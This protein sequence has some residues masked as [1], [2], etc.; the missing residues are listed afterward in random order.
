MVKSHLIIVPCHSLWKID[1]GL[2]PGNYGQS[3]K[4]WFLAPFQH[5]GR[6]HLSFV[7]HSLLAINEL[8]DDTEHSLL[9]FSGSCTKKEAGTVSEAQS[10]FLHARKLLNAVS[11]GFD[12]PL[13]FTSHEDIWKY[14][15]LIN[16]KMKSQS[17]TV[18]ELFA[19][20]I[21]VEEFALD[22]LDNLL[23]SLVKF[24]SLTSNDA[25]RVTIS[26]FGFKKTRFLELHAV[27]I[28][29]RP[30]QINYISY[31]PQ[32]ISIDPKELEAYKQNLEHQEMN[33]ALIPFRADWYATKSPL[34]DKKCQRN[35]FNLTPDYSLP[36]TRKENIENDEAFFKSTIEHKMPWSLGAQ[37]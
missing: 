16:K 33:S 6:D 21:S 11:Y 7:M 34:L 14:C 31:E 12:L 3:F 1:N 23:Y 8:L 29:Y 10:Y 5:E 15:V 20:H 26:G 9:L 37:T 2:E 4:H 22:S 35:P 13:A 28:D 19:S 32:P 27:A 30:S 24:R 25:S 36:F 18:D 17:L